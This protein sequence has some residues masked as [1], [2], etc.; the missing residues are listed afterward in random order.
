[1]RNDPKELEGALAMGALVAYSI[2]SRN[3]KSG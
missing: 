3:V 1:M 2:A